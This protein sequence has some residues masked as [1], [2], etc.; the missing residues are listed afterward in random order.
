MVTLQ[1]PLHVDR[2]D[3]KQAL[4]GKTLFVRNLPYSTKDENLEAV[5]SKY[6]QLRSCFTVKERGE[7]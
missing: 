1:I 6:G 2:M 7:D 3:E 4:A 5:F